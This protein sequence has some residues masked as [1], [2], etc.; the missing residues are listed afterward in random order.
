M[1]TM[2][3]WTGARLLALDFDLNLI[4]QKERCRE[5]VVVSIATA[6]QMELYSRC[7]ICTDY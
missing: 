5:V 3:V 6:Y 4:G 2:D 1:I 7:A